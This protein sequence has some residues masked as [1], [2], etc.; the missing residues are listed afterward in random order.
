M[1]S[2]EDRSRQTWQRL[3][4]GEKQE[5]LALLRS[6]WQQQVEREALRLERHLG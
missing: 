1:R 5:R 4:V 3:S 2:R 6:R